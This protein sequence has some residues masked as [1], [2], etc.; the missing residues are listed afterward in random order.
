MERMRRQ[1]H[2]F[3]SSAVTILSLFTQFTADW[4]KPMRATNLRS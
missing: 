4:L 2:I 3:E 1:H